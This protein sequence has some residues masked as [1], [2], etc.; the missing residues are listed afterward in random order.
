MLVTVQFYLLRVMSHQDRVVLTKYCS[1]YPFNVME[2][3][4][5][6][7]RE[8]AVVAQSVQSRVKL[9]RSQVKQYNYV[10]EAVT[11][12]RSFIFYS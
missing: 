1:I 3:R 5:T 12:Y 11:G 4:M 2:S 6:S 7:E 8:T 9:E 10:I